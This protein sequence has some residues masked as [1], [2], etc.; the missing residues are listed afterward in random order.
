MFKNTQQQSQKQ[1]MRLAPQQIQFLNLLQLPIEALEQQIKDE[2]E[3]NPALE[4]SDYSNLENPDIPSNDD[5]SDYTEEGHSDTSAED[6]SAVADIYEDIPYDGFNNTQENHYEKP[7]IHTPTFR[8]NL[9]EQLSL[10]EIE[11]KL[12]AFAEYL[13]DTIDDDGYLHQSLEDI[14]DDLSFNLN[15]FVQLEEIEKALLIVQGLEPVG[16]GSRDLQDYLMIQLREV[17]RKGTDVS[18]ACAI[19]DEFMSDLANHQYEKIQSGLA[20]NSEVLKLALHIISSLNPKPVNGMAFSDSAK[21]VITPDFIVTNDEGHLEIMVLGTT[22]HRI[23]LNPNMLET[24]NALEKSPVKSASK[25]DTAQYLKS[26]IGAAQ[27]LISALEQRNH[28]LTCTIETIVTLQQ[29]FF[30]TGDYKKLRPMILKDIAERVNLDISTISRITSS[31]Y[32]QTDFGIIPLKEL[33]TEG[34]VTEDGKI[35]S[36]RAIQE[37]IVEIVENED[38]S[39]PLNDQQITNLL[40][41]RGY[42]VARRTA[43]KYRENLNIPNAQM[44]RILQ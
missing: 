14:V 21:Q 13:I 19:V 44:R 9:K 18:V 23:Q 20:I 36:N 25:R 15:L 43:A 2:V 41:E 42:V 32:V 1:T 40:A 3:D 10:R 11:E 5:S 30:L 8:E 4:Y 31:R 37:T 16:I 38:K 28:S 34:V 22:Q 7:A 6:L 24:L 33:F 17:A 26:K 35:V 27:W 29:V 12:R 39:D